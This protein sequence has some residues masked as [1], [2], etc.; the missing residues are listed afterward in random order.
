[1]RKTNIFFNKFVLNKEYNKENKEK[2]MKKMK[3]LVNL[4]NL[5]KHLKK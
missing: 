2:N 4:I 5:Q 1:M 3:K